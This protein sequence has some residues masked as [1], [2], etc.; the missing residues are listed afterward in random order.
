MKTCIMPF[1]GQIVVASLP[2]HGFSQAASR[3]GLG[4]PEIAQLMFALMKRLGH[5]KFYVS[6]GG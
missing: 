6:G 1:C 3:D 4:T 2:G 5:D